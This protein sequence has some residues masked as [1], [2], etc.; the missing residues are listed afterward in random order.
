[1]IYALVT[2]Y[3]PNKDVIENIKIL[4]S[5]VDIVY[6]CDNS[7]SQNMPM[8][9]EIKNCTYV[10]N[11]AN[12]GLSQAFNRILKNE[13]YRFSDDDFI[14]FFDQDSRISDSYIEEL[15]AEYK[16]IE[17]QGIPI[18]CL[19]PVYYDSGSGKIEIPIKKKY[20][21]AHSFQV[22][23]IITSSMLCRYKNLKFVNFWTEQV[24]LD[25]ADWDICWKFIKSNLVCCMTDI[26]TLHHSL[27]K[28]KKKLL[29]FSIQEWNPIRVYYQTRDSIFLLFRNYSPFKFKIR[30]LYILFLRPIVYF[31]FLN[32]RKQRLY[33]YIKGIKDYF[34]GKNDSLI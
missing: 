4:S 27:G 5:Q 19:G 15:M 14:I 12:L 20:I 32:K 28:G 1:M 6:L 16:T 13:K 8:F 23:S 21:S 31:I 9:E 17:K 26:V 11:G 24:F 2:I 10:F 34:C 30:F 29:C 33:Y 7:S 22:K 25:M 3:S 18:G